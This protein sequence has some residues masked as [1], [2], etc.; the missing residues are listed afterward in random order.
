[1]ENIICYFDGA[2]GPM[3]P[4]GDMGFGAEIRSTRPN[5][6]LAT[7]Y[8]GLPAS[9][10]NSSN[11]AEYKA[12]RWTLEWLI[13]NEM[14]DASITIVGDSMLVVNQMS[15]RWRIKNGF[16]V[17]EALMCKK[18]LRG[19]SRCVIHWVCREKNARADELSKMGI[20]LAR[21]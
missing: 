9:P 6:V 21:N 12:L 13:D 1:M 10:R 16:Y 5:D 18:L 14:T 8:G 11:V 17:S 7:Y 15:G 20:I 3:N 19:F 2:C 4:G